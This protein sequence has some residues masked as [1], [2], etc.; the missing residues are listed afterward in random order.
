MTKRPVYRLET[1]TALECAPDEDPERR[2]RMAAFVN[3][4]DDLAPGD[5]IHLYAP[6]IGCTMRRGGTR[7]DFRGNAIALEMNEHGEF[8]V[9]S[10]GKDGAITPIDNT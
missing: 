10:K 6:L 9:I 3:I 7:D 1:N 4:P 8:C 2:R 5:R